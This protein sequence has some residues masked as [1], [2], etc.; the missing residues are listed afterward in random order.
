MQHYLES[1]GTAAEP[2]IFSSRPTDDQPP[3]IRRFVMRNESTKVF[4]SDDHVPTSLPARKSTSPASIGDLAYN[5]LSH[6]STSTMAPSDQV[7]S[8]LAGL[9]F[10]SPA[11]AVETS[12]PTPLAAAENGEQVVG[13]SVPDVLLWAR[14]HKYGDNDDDNASTSPTESTKQEHLDLLY[15]T[16]ES[17]DRA[18]N[19]P[20]MQPAQEAAS[21]KLPRAGSTEKSISIRASSTIMAPDYGM[22]RMYHISKATA[23][24]TSQPRVKHQ[25]GAPDWM[26]KTVSEA[27]REQQKGRLILPRGV[28]I[29]LAG[30]GKEKERDDINYS[31]HASDTPPAPTPVKY[32]DWSAQ[33]ENKLVE[34]PMKAKEKEEEF[35]FW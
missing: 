8:D 6:T 12:S 26:N 27:M 32:Q 28:P 35:S 30:K 22:P 21:S 24:N 5:T 17:E 18:A 23:T 33:V 3:L 10:D 16:T 31:H 19:L 13:L 25:P 15:L 14:L 7:T 29:L 34:Q 4:S 9:V 1:A 2:A 11:P 20:I